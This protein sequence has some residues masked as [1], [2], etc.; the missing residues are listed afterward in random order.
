MDSLKWTLRGVKHM[1][2]ERE[3][4]RET[5][6]GCYVPKDYTITDTGTFFIQI[7]DG[8]EKWH[9]I[10][11]VKMMVTGRYS[12][13]D[14]IN[15]VEVRF[16]DKNREYKALVPQTAINGTKEFKEHLRSRNLRVL[17]DRIKYALNFLNNCVDENED[18]KGSQ[19]VCADS[20][21]RTG[22]KGNDFTKFNLGRR[23][24]IDAGGYAKEERCE[25]TEEA[26]A[27]LFDPVGS[28]EEWKKYVNPFL[29]FNRARAAFYMAFAATLLRL[30]GVDPFTY[31]MYGGI[32]GSYNDR[33]G[34]GKTTMMIICCSA[35]CIVCPNTGNSLFNPC[36]STQNFVE[37]L[38]AKT[39]DLPIFLDETTKLN[40]EEREKLSYKISAKTTKGKASDG[41]GGVVKSHV[42][43]NVAMC[44]GEIPLVSNRANVGAQIRDIAVCGGM[45]V[46]G[47]G[48]I[49][50]T[51]STGVSG[52]YPNSG[53]IT[54][55]Y[56]NSL[57]KLKHQLKDFYLEAKKR[58]EN[59]VESDMSK[60]QAAYFAV[61][62]TA[63]YILEDAFKE[64]GID[65]K[66]PKDVMDKLWHDAVLSNER[67]PQWLTALEQVWQWI[68]I[69]KDKNFGYVKTSERYGWIV[70]NPDDRD[71]I[72]VHIFHSS[73][74]KY[75]EEQGTGYDVTLESWLAK[76]LIIRGEYRTHKD[77]TVKPLTTVK[78]SYDG[79]RQRVVA[80]KGREVMRILGFG[81]CNFITKEQSD[82]ASKV[83]EQFFDNYKPQEDLPKVRSGY[84]YPIDNIKAFIP[85]IESSD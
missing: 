31:D 36:E 37:N 13:E 17:D 21:S 52:T 25:F 44:T 58:F 60:R 78:R 59:T 68:T 18:V 42:K 30:L 16:I 47:I 72:T 50:S 12:N 51:A 70:T 4:N 83:T 24:F 15:F 10:T 48:D 66:D 22:W 64:I 8:E 39:L 40:D 2:E 65:P 20:Y 55:P 53:H 49:V 35:F 80:L 85:P 62:E 67:K 33:S 19:F 3:N 73:L 61:A 32:A 71:D 14:G 28:F 79:I 77:G 76:D 57:Y 75:L 27:D 81:A 45:N 84:D 6:Y 5:R 29:A 82:A 74:E 54:Y 23:M 7:K 11:S 69:N 26:I 1:I 38:S 46:S 9:K 41:K 63:G 56:F 43:S 34:S